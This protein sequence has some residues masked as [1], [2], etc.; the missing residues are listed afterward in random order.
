MSFAKIITTGSYLPKKVVTNDDL[1]VKI[2]TSDEWIVQRTGIRRRHIA[3]DRETTASMGVEA[4]KAALS[5]IN[6][7]EIDLIIVATCTPDQIFP[8]TA[9]AIQNQLNIPQ[10]MAFDVHAACNGFMHALS[11]ATQY[12]ENNQARKV[13]V[14]GTEA[15]SRVL[16]WTD[17]TICVLFGDG[18]GAIVLAASDEPG[19]LVTKLVANGKYGELLYL[20]N[21]NVSADKYI[22]MDGNPLF[23]LAVNFLGDIANEVIYLAGLKPSDIDW[24]VPHQANI[25]I[26]QAITKKLGIPMDRVIV[27]VAEHANTSSASIPMALDYGIRSGKI[28]EGQHLLLEA[29]GGGLTWGA[30]LVRY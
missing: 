14:V 18:A 10:C 26:L 19:V 2:D 4:C 15:M 1:A 17:R 6:V 27:T 5:G 3:V 28:Q 23:R 11:I 9:C 16:D 13:L 24:L 25:R 12:I 7:E 21:A 22:R 8:S 30:A 20:N 29:F